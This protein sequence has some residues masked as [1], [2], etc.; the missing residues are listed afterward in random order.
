VTSTFAPISHKEKILSKLEECAVELATDMR[1]TGWVGKTVTVK[2][3]LDTYQ[4]QPLTQL[5]GAMWLI[6]TKRSIH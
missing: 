4:G 6:I 3:K 2:F 5:E 1:E